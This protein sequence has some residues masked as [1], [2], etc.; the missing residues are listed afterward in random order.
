M[1]SWLELAKQQQEVIDNA[2]EAL[3]VTKKTQVKIEQQIGYADKA[4]GAHNVNVE[5]HPDMREQM[6]RF[7]DPPAITGPKAIEYGEKNTWT[8]QGSP[9][10]FVADKVKVEKYLIDLM[11]GTRIEVPADESGV[12]T[13]EYAFEGERNSAIWFTAMTYGGKSVSDKT[14]HEML[15]TKHI[16]PDLS[17]MT[18]TLPSA[19]NAGT[20]HTFRFNGIVDEDSDL[21]RIDIESSSSNITLSLGA[22][23]Q[24]DTDYTITVGAGVRGPEN[25]NFTFTATDA[26]GLKS[27]R[28]YVVHINGIPDMSNFTHTLPNRLTANTTSIGRFSGITDPDGFATEIRLAIQSSIPEITFGKNSGIKLNEDVSVIVGEV[29]PGTSYELTV[30][31]TDK[32]GGTNTTTINSTINRV[33]DISTLNTNIKPYMYPSETHPNVFFNGVVDADDKT[34]TYSVETDYPEIIQF[35]KYYNIAENENITLY[36]TSSAVRGN[37]YTY[38]VIATDTSLASVKTTREIRINRKITTSDIEYSCPGLFKCIEPGQSYNIKFTPEQDPDGQTLNYTLRD[39]SGHLTFEKVDSNTFSITAPDAATVPRGTKCTVSAVADD[40]YEKVSR[41]VFFYQNQLPDNSKF[42][43]LTVKYLTAGINNRAVVTGVTDPDKTKVTFHVDSS[44]NSITFP[45]NDTLVPDI[46]FDIAVAHDAVPGQEFTLT[47]TFTD[48][49]GG[50]V[51]STYTGHINAAPDITNMVLEGLPETVIPGTPYTL[52]VHGAVDPNSEGITYS[53]QNPVVGLSFSKMSQIGEN[54]EV[55]MMVSQEVKRGEGISFV[56]AAI[57]PSNAATG[58][59]YTAKVNRILEGNTAT[60]WIPRFRHPNTVT[61]ADTAPIADD[62]G[63]A[64]TYSITSDTP[65]VSFCTQDTAEPDSLVEDLVSL[66]RFTPT[67]TKKFGFKVSP[68]IVRGTIVALRVTATDGLETW[69]SETNVYIKQIPTNFRL[70]SDVD[71]QG[72]AEFSEDHVFTWDDPDVANGYDTALTT[73]TGFVVDRY[74]IGQLGEKYSSAQTAN[75]CSPKV[76]TD[77]TKEISV[78]LN[79]SDGTTVVDQT[80]SFIVVTH[81]I[82]VTAPPTITYPIEGQEVP[83]EGYTLTWTEAKGMIDMDD[84][85]P[86]PSDGSEP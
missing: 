72:G 83:Y 22:D 29:A 53:F 47:F 48:A 64:I 34:V 84:E 85:H 26:R 42:N 3:V 63:Q 81:P 27:T 49:D 80:Y 36:I 52:R 70:D 20:T 16:P 58:R 31:A 71:L 30:T 56:L 55:T 37:V 59:T 82:E 24:Q 14:T 33:P 5:A 9:R 62:D 21:A 19:V 50:V 25:V 32:D 6:T 60:A 41:N 76:E 4:V 61:W 18:C 78:T 86:Y 23:V 67:N 45:V 2:T 35:S 13:W 51:Q 12:G 10:P 17:K 54:E 11:D 15:L 46:P 40:G 65:L 28:V 77:T 69:R 43:L 8:F 74:K 44:L 38:R 66:D 1:V 75:V 39:L 79:I 73:W 57:D 7:F 68:N